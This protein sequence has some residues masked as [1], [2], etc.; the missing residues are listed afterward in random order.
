MQRSSWRATVTMHVIGRH[1]ALLVRFWSTIFGDHLFA[2]WSWLVRFSRDIIPIRTRINPST[3]WNLGW[4]GQALRG[5]FFSAPDSRPSLT[6]TSSISD[7]SFRSFAAMETIQNGK[8]NGCHEALNERQQEH[9]KNRYEMKTGWLSN[10]DWVMKSMDDTGHQ[11]RLQGLAVSKRRCNHENVICL[12]PLKPGETVN[13][14]RKCER[15]RIGTARWRP[16]KL[17]KLVKRTCNPEKE[18]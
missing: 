10:C 13:T 8:E 16:W 2:L 11:H 15:D 18:R 9:R 5:V 4:P 7:N 3:R 6:V 14:N 17:G 1:I 12:K